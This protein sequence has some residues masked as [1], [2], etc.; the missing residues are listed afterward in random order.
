MFTLNS[1]GTQGGFCWGFKLCGLP[2]ERR[3]CGILQ[4]P[5]VMDN[6]IN[7]AMTMRSGNDAVLARIDQYDV[8]RELG[9]GGFGTVYLARDTV[10]GVEVAVKG[11]PPFVKNSRDEL[12]NIRRNF[13]LVSRLHHPG[14]AAALVLHPAVDVGYFDKA[15]SEK[16]RVFAGD[17]LMVMEYAPG[18]TLSQWRRQ[19]PDNRVP[20][21]KAIAITRQIAEAL[22]YA[23]ER[24]II[25]RDI[26]PANVMI[27]TSVDGTV[28]ARVLDFGL[29]AEIRSS[30][31]RISMEVHDTSGTRPYMAPEQWSGDRQGPATDQYALAVLFYELITGEVPFASVFDCGDPIVMLSTVTTRPASIPESL[32]KAIRNALGISLEKTP[33]ARFA[34]CRDFVAALEGKKVCRTTGKHTTVHGKKVIAAGLILV[35]AAMVGVFGWHRYRQQQ[36]VEQQRLAQEEEQRKLDAMAKAEAERK[37]AAAEAK[38]KE[39]AE[40]KSLAEAAEKKR[41][42]AER[43]AKAIQERAAELVRV[44]TRI[45]I[46]KSEAEAKLKRID[47]FRADAEGLETR[48]KS[49]DEQRK[50]L[51]ALA[52]PEGL[53]EAKAVLDMA[54]KAEAQIALDLEWLEKNNVAR[55]AAR[56]AD[57]AVTDL[58]SSDVVTYKTEKY[59]GKRL[60]DGKELLAKGR[61]AF[62]RGDIAEAG[63]LLG[64]TK[65]ILTDAIAEAKASF[66]RITLDAARGYA[67][68]GKWLDC[69]SEC[70]KI[71]GGDDRPDWDPD[72]VEA[73]KLKAEAERNL[74]P[75]ARINFI[76]DG[77]MLGA[78]ESVRIG[79]S[80]WKTPVVWD[81]KNIAEGKKYG[82]LAVYKRDGKRYVGELERF[83][84]N[85]RGPKDFNVSLSESLEGALYCVID[86]SA[87]PRASHYAVSYTD[88]LPENGFNTEE[89]KTTKLVLR[90]IEPGTFTMGSADEKNNKPHQVTLTKPFY[91]GIFEVT[92]KQYE[93]VMGMN[94]SAIIQ[95]LAK[96]PLTGDMRPVERVSWDMIRGDSSKY[97]WPSSAKVAPDS[98]MGR[99][100]DRTGL[101][102]DLPTEAQWEYACRAGTTSKYNNGCDSMDDL[103]QLEQLGPN[104]SKKKCDSGGGYSDGH[105]TVGSYNPNAWGFHD[106]HGNVAEWCL[107]GVGDPITPLTDDATDPVG[108]SSG[109]RRVR[110]GGGYGV[111]MPSSERDSL[112]PFV[113]SRDDTGFRIARTLSK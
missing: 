28:T 72:N 37:R 41:Q 6:S 113:K 81:G 90:R 104:R 45:N 54:D 63:R 102:F 85:W 86:L 82:R 106:M 27:E 58:L 111:N 91:C 52:V 20:M 46:K 78:G 92:Q 30:M 29:A 36:I 9:G 69:E 56:L 57:K 105:T 21:D 38:A 19:F 1:S 110:R 84:G 60:Q 55:D 35:L 17:T 79:G 101:N 96:R 4:I 95:L 77:V 112:N 33:S 32:P 80:D 15:T 64:D 5:L 62:K 25:H 71:L 98:F 42:E 70:A 108:I 109:C 24:R 51:F 83:T 43:E 103:K 16:L 74:Q 97:N 48:L 66:V 53:E 76:L 23:H 10:S 47:A 7:S 68:A 22:D 73:K 34:N 99:L 2:R 50:T 31:G 61:E 94:P 67:D 11:L 59:A 93:L 14:I 8:I 12:E 65:A 39:E 75:S 18:V 100:Q 49:A 87:G 3:G 107:D 89:Y 44:K 40:K 26:K 88:D 13:V